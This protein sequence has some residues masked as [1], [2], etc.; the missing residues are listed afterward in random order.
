M[1]DRKGSQVCVGREIAGDAGAKQK[2]T[3]HGVMLFCRLQHLGS[4]LVEP[5]PADG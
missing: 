5:S 4:R 3:Q 1:F 2:A